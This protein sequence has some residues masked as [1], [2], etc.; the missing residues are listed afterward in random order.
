MFSTLAAAAGLFVATNID[1]IVVL[2]LFFARGA[3]RKGTAPAILVGQYLGFLGILATSAIVGL[4]F[5]AVLP[6]ELIRYFGLIPLLLGLWAAWQAFRGEDDDEDVS[7]K[8]LSA[9][10]VAGVTFANGGDNIGVYVPVFTTSMPAEVA[11]YCVVFLILVAPLVW[12]A[13]F[14]ATRPGI[15]EALE[16]W[17]SVLFPAVLILLGIAILLVGVKRQNVCPES[18]IFML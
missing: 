5:N 16:K 8:R 1:D 6:E 2:S 14:V 12:A 4:G 7:G 10:A 11:I 15:A 9:L 17:E 13:R 3:G 18:L